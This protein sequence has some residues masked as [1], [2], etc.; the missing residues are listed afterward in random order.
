VHT[1]AIVAWGLLAVVR[2]A[3]FV[4]PA[5]PAW[6]QLLLWLFSLPALLFLLGL[7]NRRLAQWR[8]VVAIW[9]AYCGLRW[10]ITWLPASPLLRDNL[11]NLVGVLVVDALI[12]GFV[13]LTALAIRRDV[14]VLYIALA[15]I[16][17]GLALRGQVHMAGGVLNWLLGTANTQMQE[18]F[19]LVEPLTMA[20]S[21]MITL[22]LVTF[23]PHLIWSGIRELRGR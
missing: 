8:S 3:L 7:Y 15:L 14:S 12:A 20:G 5:A 10:L 4:A 19:S 9:L 22:G 2:G 17:G 13:G 18:G 11:V 16:F 6:A 1:L 21:C 23:L